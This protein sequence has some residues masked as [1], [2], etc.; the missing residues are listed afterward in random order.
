MQLPLLKLI[1]FVA[2]SH[3]IPHLPNFN[4]I[5]D[6]VGYLF[7]HNIVQLGDILDVRRYREGNDLQIWDQ[8]HD[9]IPAVLK[10]QYREAK[11]RSEAILEWLLTHFELAL[12]SGESTDMEEGFPDGL[13]RADRL[14]TM[15]RH[16]FVQQCRT[17]VLGRWEAYLRNVQ[18]MVT[19]IS[20]L[21]LRLKLL[22]TA[23]SRSVKAR[24]IRAFIEEAFKDKKWFNDLWPQQYGNS[25]AEWINSWKENDPRSFAWPP[26]PQGFSYKMIRI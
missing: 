18:G 11:M 4:L 13:K 12:V 26:A 16:F 24:R 2:G 21:I 19:N 6:V 1:C 3:I 14:L 25:T 23:E 22:N 15:S 8:D 20:A 17:L 5:D 9:F 7:L 10:K